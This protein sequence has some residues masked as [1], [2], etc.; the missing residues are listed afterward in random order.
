MSIYDEED[1]EA[2]LDKF[3]KEDHTLYKVIVGDYNAK[4]RPRRSPEEIHIGT[5]CLECERLP[6]EK[7]TKFKKRS[8]R[9][10]INC[11]LYISLAGL[12]EDTAMDN[13]DEECDRFVHHLRD[14]AKGVDSLKTTKRPECYKTML[15][16]NGRVSGAPFS[17]NGTTITECSRY[18]YLDREISIA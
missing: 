18:V 16:R 12:W 6:E 2:E 10:T 1:A 14:S 8:S 13:I 17:L 15:V 3:Y 9:T 5:H 11:N 4:I 7:A